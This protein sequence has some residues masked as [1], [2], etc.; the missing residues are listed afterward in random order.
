M[1]LLVCG[2]QPGS[3]AALRD[4]PRASAL[5]LVEASR[6]SSLRVW[7]QDLRELGLIQRDAWEPQAAYGQLHLIQSSLI[8]TSST[9]YWQYKTIDS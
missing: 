5:T 4:W 6:D 7:Q 2:M 1:R 8:F 9:S 3:P